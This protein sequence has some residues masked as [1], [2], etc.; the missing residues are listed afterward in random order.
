MQ[1]NS[2]LLLIFILF[3]IASCQRFE[4]ESNLLKPKSIGPQNGTLLIGGGGRNNGMSDEMWK[5]F[6]DLAGGHSAHLIVIPTAFDDGSIDYDPE[7]K[8]LDRKF[9]AIG[10]SN[11]QYLHTRD[12]LLANSDEFVEPLKNATAVWFTGGRQ[13]RLADTYLNTKTHEELL[14]VLDRGGIIGGASAGASIQGSYLA[15]GGRDS[16]GNYKLIG[17]PDVGLGFVTNT[18]FD[19]HYLERNRQFDMFELLEKRPELLGI[20]IDQNTAII[21]RGNEFEVIGERY[22]AIYDGTFW[23]D[24]FNEIDTTESANRKFYFL[25][26]GDKYNLKERRVQRNRF[27][28][29]K[30]ISAESQSE[31]LG[32]YLFEKSK[33]FWNNIILENDTLKFQVVRRMNVNDPI[34]I[35]PYGKDLFFDIDDE[36]WFHFQ[37]DS[38]GKISGFEKKEHQFIDGLNQRFNRVDN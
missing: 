18:V 28:N 26:N 27:L 35:H 33:V 23:S 3:T 1:A 7:F 29:P 17:E 32:E 5:V 30:P 9:K 31:Y 38:S 14:K 6:Y 19:Q 10:F 20:G 15:R 24:Y 25:E 22:V 16:N 37:R 8:I 12:P 13:W 36:L 4:K 21:V 11:I 2:S 34:P